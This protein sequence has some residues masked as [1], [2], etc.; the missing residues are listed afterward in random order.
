M[1]SMAGPFLF[2]EN[3]VGLKVELLF[4]NGTSSDDVDSLLDSRDT[5]LQAEND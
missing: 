1:L 2:F 4:C 3:K 5:D